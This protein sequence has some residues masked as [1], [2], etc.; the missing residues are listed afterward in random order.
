M[1][2]QCVLVARQ[3]ITSQAAL[4]KGVPAE[5]LVPLINTRESISGVLGPDLGSQHKRDIDVLE[6]VQQRVTKVIKSLKHLKEKGRLRRL[7][8]FSLVKRR[9]R[10][11]LITGYQYLMGR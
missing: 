4:G 8:L 1:L 10:E 5:T 9:S 3:D 7:R 2:H 6:Q 11:D